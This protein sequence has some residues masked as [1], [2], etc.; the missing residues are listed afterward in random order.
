MFNFNK[1]IISLLFMLFLTNMVFA[2]GAPQD[3]EKEQPEPF[4]GVSLPADMEGLKFYENNYAFI[5]YIDVVVTNY[6][7]DDDRKQF[8]KAIDHHLTAQEF[9]LRRKFLDQYREIRKS[10]VELAGVLQRLITTQYSKYSLN[11]LNATNAMV[12][13]A[14]DPQARSHLKNGYYAYERAEGF[15]QRGAFTNKFQYSQK[16]RYY[17]E[18]IEQF[19][20]A[21]RMSVRAIIEV[22]TPL[23]IKGAYKSQTLGDYISGRKDIKQEPYERIRLALHSLQKRPMLSQDD[24]FKLSERNQDNFG[25][26]YK[27]KESVFLQHLQSKNAALDYYQAPE[28]SE[29]PPLEN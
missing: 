3:P 24:P 15:Y 17:I 25:K 10:H 27:D 2:L 7:Q 23:A 4:S 9:Q 20:L 6:G 28:N 11:L 5:K 1:K 13:L 14:N 8:N 26:F 18:A 19:R 21:N 12:A 29:L 22:K 16:I